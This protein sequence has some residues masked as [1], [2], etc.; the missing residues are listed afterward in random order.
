MR[1]Y[2]EDVKTALLKLPAGRYKT[3][4]I[5]PPWDWMRGGV[6]RAGLLANSLE[7]LVLARW[8]LRPTPA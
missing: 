1:R 5:D 2:Q 3:L 7:R 6:R 8:G 4:Y